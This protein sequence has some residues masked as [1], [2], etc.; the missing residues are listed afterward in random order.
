MNTSIF[1]VKI[2]SQPIQSFFIGDISIVE[3][4]VEFPKAKKKK[5]FQDIRLS[6]W[7]DLG[8]DICKYYKIGDYV[9]VEGFLSLRT[10]VSG[11]ILDKEPEFTITKFYPFL[12]TE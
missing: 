6:I 10:N 11:I 7:G 4:I 2:V 8:G 9:I 3:I 1:I 5:S 12:L